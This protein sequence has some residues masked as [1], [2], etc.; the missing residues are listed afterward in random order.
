MKSKKISQKNKET[1]KIKK[2][3]K[4]TKPVAKKIKKVVK[5]AK[6][7]A[8]KVSKP[9]AAPKS[10][11]VIAK[12]PNIKHNKLV[13]LSSKPIKITSKPTKNKPVPEIFKNFYR[14]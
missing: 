14:E 2:P 5:V 8:K 10:K 13:E 6:P 9:I 1:K 7:V 12:T 3:A 11:K 4:V